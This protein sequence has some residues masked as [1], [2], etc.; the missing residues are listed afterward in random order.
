MNTDKK[1]KHESEKK[2]LIIAVM[3]SGVFLAV[4]NQTVLFPASWKICI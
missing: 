2:T 1:A 4:L 3:I